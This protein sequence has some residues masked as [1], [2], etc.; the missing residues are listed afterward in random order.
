M[1]ELCAGLSNSLVIILADHG[2]INSSGFNIT[3]DYKDFADTLKQDIFIEARATAFIVK[4][5]RKDDFE[6]LFKKYFG[7]YFLLLTKEEILSSKIFGTSKDN[8]KFEKLLGDYLAIA[9]SDKYF[10]YTDASVNLVSH[11]AGITE[12]EMIV[13]IIV[14]EKP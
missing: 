7:N 11:H 10:R 3:E 6:R 13:P 14:I 2:H 12:D 8:P 1:E 4:D 5:G 9:Y